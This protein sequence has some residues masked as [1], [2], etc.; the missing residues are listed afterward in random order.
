[1]AFYGKQKKEHD[2]RRFQ[3]DLKEDKFGELV[4]FCGE[5]EYLS[6]WACEML[7]EKYINPVTKALDLDVINLELAQADDIIT[8]CET[9]PMLSERKIVLL[10]HY[11]GEF[12]SELA[13]Y[14]KDMPSTVLLV[15]TCKEADKRLSEKASLYEFGPLYREELEGFISKRFK[16]ADKNVSRGIITTLIN[17]S[18]YLNKDIDYNLYNLQGDLKKIIALSGDEITLDDIRSGISDNLEHGV[19][20]LLDAI[21]GNRKDKAFDL[22]HQLLLSG[23]DRFKLLASVISQLELMLQAKEMSEGG[24]KIGEIKKALK[25]H[26]YRVQKALDFARSYSISDLKRILSV[27]YTTDTRIK[28]GLLEGQLALEMLIAEI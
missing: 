4:L 9:A 24:L 16:A 3:R 12:A 18:G 7:I 8:S 6:S 13:D 25:A 15:I 11:N 5:E 10:K 27:A 26:E 21:S 1:M 23:T 17:E 20:T 28:S 14:A 2:F 22:L 19:F